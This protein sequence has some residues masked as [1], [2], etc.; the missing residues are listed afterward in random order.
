MIME[1]SFALYSHDWA[2]YL[3]LIGIQTIVPKQPHKELCKEAMTEV[4]IPMRKDTHNDVIRQTDMAMKD[5]WQIGQVVYPNG[6]T[7]IDQR[8]TGTTLETRIKVLIRRQH[9]VPRFP[10]WVRKL[11]SQ[12]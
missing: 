8:D 2:E 9:R 4:D 12:N 11:T 10:D 6:V 7:V 5:I 1:H 3:M